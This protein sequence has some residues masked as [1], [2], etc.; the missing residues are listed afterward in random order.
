MK[1]TTA[2]LLALLV[3]MAALSATVCAAEIDLIPADADWVMT[4]A[5]RLERKAW[6]YGEN[7][8]YR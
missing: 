4:E 7:G 5:R 8:S 3:A 1:K 2:V 6:S